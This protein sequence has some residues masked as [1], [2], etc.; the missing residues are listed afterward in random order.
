MRR[1]LPALAMAG[2]CVL[3]VALLLCGLAA[4]YH[5]PELAEGAMLSLAAGVC[6]VGLAL[7]GQWLISR[8]V[9]AQY[10]ARL[11]YI[12]RGDCQCDSCWWRNLP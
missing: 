11:P 8:R 9:Q 7:A 2:F 5:R 6:L 3:S 12:H 10:V 1:H 4:G